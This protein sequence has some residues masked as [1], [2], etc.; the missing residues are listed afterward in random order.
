M[1]RS[2]NLSDTE[3]RKIVISEIEEFKKLIKGHEKVLSAI[4]RL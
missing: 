1:A 2:E 4:G 3:I